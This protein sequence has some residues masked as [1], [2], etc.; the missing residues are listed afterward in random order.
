MKIIVKDEQEARAVVIACGYAIKAA[1]QE[2]PVEIILQVTD[3]AVVMS[4]SI[5]IDS[6]PEE[7]QCQKAN[8][9]KTC[10]KND[11]TK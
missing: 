4:K 10:A 9:T 1:G 7:P 6:N 5:M 8:S 2:K 11:S 3:T